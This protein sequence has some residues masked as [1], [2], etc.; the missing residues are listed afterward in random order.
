MWEHAHNNIQHTFKSQQ[1]SGLKV[2]ENSSGITSVFHKL[3]ELLEEVVPLFRIKL[4]LGL[5][6]Q[7]RSQWKQGMQSNT[8]FVQKHNGKK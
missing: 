4:F 5:R 3:I 7:M 2:K 6:K 1:K 8:W